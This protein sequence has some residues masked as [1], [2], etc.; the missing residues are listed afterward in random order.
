MKF[1]FGQQKSSPENP[2]K[3]SAKEILQKMLGPK[4]TQKSL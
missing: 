1:S 3:L 4:D 2:Q